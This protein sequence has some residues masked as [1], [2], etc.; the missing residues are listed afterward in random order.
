M[1]MILDASDLEGHA[2]QTSDG[3]T[4]VLVKAQAPLGPE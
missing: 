3:S 4:E 1:N 2:L